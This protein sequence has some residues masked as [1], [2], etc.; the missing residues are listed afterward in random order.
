MGVA[1]TWYEGL[2]SITFTWT[3]WKEQLKL[4]F[5]DYT[6]L[7]ER[8]TTML[9]RTKGKDES[10]MQYYFA[11]LALVISC[12]IQ[13]K[14]AAA[15][16]AYGIAN[17]SLR[18]TI[19]K[20]DFQTPK[21]LRVFLSKAEE[22]PDNHGKKNHSKNHHE[23][24]HFAGQQRNSYRFYQSAKKPRQEPIKQEKRELTRGSAAPA[25]KLADSVRRYRCN[26]TGHIARHCSESKTEN[27]EKKVLRIETTQPRTEDRR[28]QEAVVN[29]TLFKA[30]VDAGSQ[31]VT[32]RKADTMQLGLQPTEVVL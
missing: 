19:K 12:N 21:E 23:R 13:G 3:E 6:E 11:K 1:R 31:C 15:C 17:Y 27:K 28:F 32:L 14:E 18:M 7:P 26:K 25:A 30:Y 20:N 5:T 4:A 9:A 10:M 2:P 22:L 24:Q 29:G 8:L 16:I